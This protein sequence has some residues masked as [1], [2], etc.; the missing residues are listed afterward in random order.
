MHEIILNLTLPRWATQKKMAP[1]AI[2]AQRVPPVRCAHCPLL[3]ARSS[4]GHELFQD[5][6]PVV[7]H[8]LGHPVHVPGGGGGGGG[9]CGGGG[10]GGGE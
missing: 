3:F 8:F 9:G 2:V 7:D 10:G 4:F 5:N 1:R 6:E